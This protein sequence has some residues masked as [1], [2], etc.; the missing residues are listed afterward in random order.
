MAADDSIQT[1]RDPMTRSNLL[2]L[3]IGVLVVTVAVLGYQV[4]QAK[5]EPK[6]IELKINER[7]VSI[8]TK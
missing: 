7:G 5:K 1:R 6:G 2:Y 4:Y 3:V 8:E